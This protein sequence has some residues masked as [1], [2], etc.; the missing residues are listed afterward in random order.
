M[1]LTM[2]PVRA[3]WREVFDNI[4]TG[5][6]SVHHFDRHWKAELARSNALTIAKCSGLRLHTQ[7]K[8]GVLS[9]NGCYQDID[10]DVVLIVWF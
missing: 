1:E 10:S 3:N 7:V 2:P 9:T 5:Q 4:P 8:G 6:A